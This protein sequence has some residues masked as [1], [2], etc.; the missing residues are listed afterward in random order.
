LLALYSEFRAC[1][2]DAPDRGAKLR[3]FEEALYRASQDGSFNDQLP[4]DGIRA[5]VHSTWQDK[6]R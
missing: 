5:W 1:P 3:V 2:E 6:Q 4:P